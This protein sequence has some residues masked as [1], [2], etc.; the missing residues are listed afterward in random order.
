MPAKGQKI[1]EE[2]REA[3]RAWHR[4]QNKG[5]SPTKRCPKCQETKPRD[6]FGLRPPN[7]Q[8]KRYSKSYCHECENLIQMTKNREDP[9]KV[10]ARNKVTALSRYFNMT[11]EEFNELDD[12]QNGLCAICEKAPPEGRRLHIDHDHE[13]GLVRGLLCRGCNHGLGNFLDSPTLLTRAIAYLA[14]GP[15]SLADGTTFSANNAEISDRVRGSKDEMHEGKI[16]IS[17]QLKAARGGRTKVSIAKAIGTT[18]QKVSQWESSRT[19]KGD[20][21]V[22]FSLTEHYGMVVGLIDNNE[23]IVAYPE[24]LN[25]VD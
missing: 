6:A 12:Q 5:Q 25:L 1:S 24:A 15:A 23:L 8:G 18:P 16:L 11:P 9:A 20:I 13:S 3:L 14:Q 10:S 19:M 21:E 22:L 4:G 7:P 2:H 17:E